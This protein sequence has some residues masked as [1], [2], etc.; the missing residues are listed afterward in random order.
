MDVSDNERV[1][2]WKQQEDR[3]YQIDSRATE[4]SSLSV[5]LRMLRHEIEIKP[6]MQTCDAFLRPKEVN[7]TSYC[8]YKESA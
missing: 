1:P 4:A 3:D 6:K 2:D 7:A 8:M 5:R